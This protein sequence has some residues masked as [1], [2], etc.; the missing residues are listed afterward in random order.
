MGWELWLF[1]DIS[2][3]VL[4]RENL[5]EASM[6]GLQI[7]I[8]LPVKCSWDDSVFLVFWLFTLHCREVHGPFVA[9]ESL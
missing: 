9:G 3:Q 2:A 7:T 5:Q 6:K 8:I 4:F 1:R